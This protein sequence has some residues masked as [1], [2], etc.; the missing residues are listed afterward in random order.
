M[1]SV[2][3]YKRLRSFD[4]EVAFELQPGTCLALIGPTGCGKTTALRLIAGLDRPEHGRVLICDQTVVDTEARLW[5]PPEKRRVG[6]VFQDY[7]L[8]PHLTVLGNVTYSAAARAMGKA[9]AVQAAREALA[10]VQLPGVEDVRPSEL[11]GGQQQRVAIARAI[12][13]GAQLL[14]MDEPMSALDALTR[15]QVRSDLKALIT[16]LKLDTIVVTHDVADALTLG[17]VVGVMQEGK[18]VQIG[19]RRDLLASP[20]SPFVA[21]FLGINL[22]SGVASPH[23]DGLTEVTCGEHVFYGLTPMEGE[24]LVTLQPWDITLS[25]EPP[26][27]SAVNVLKGTLTSLSHLG[28]RTRVVV[29]N[30]VSLVAELTHISEERLGLRLGQTVYASFKA[31]A[32]RL[33]N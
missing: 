20:R 12:V 27:T 29:E 16:E 31:S 13:S 28:G 3:L 30:G 9:K 24:T 7:A 8:F 23:D 4:L 21:E 11:S 15:R 32:L 26:E 2:S 1:T 14:L 25:I 19:S 22:L 18:L 10:R 33:H 6:L 5:L 17:D